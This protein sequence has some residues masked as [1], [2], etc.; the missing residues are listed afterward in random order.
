MNEKYEIHIEEKRL[1][2]MLMKI[3]ILE[4]QNQ[5]DKCFTEQE[6]MDK[7]REIIEEEATC[8]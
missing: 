8:K 5:K 7:I 2:M 6:M 1:N 4:K 3:I